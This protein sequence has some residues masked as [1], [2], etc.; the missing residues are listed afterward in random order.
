MLQ[1][2]KGTAKAILG[3]GLKAERGAFLGWVRVG[4]GRGEKGAGRGEE[5]LGRISGLGETRGSGCDHI[6][7][8]TCTYHPHLPWIHTC[9]QIPPTT[10][11]PP[12]TDHTYRMCKL[13]RFSRVHCAICTFTLERTWKFIFDMFILENILEQMYIDN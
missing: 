8:T 1:G 11:T 5:G 2:H 12:Y 4:V 3:L 13:S 10:H 6:T 9:T 7:Y